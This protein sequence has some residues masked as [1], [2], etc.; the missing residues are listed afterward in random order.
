MKYDRNMGN[1]LN[2]KISEQ[3]M[4]AENAQNDLTLMI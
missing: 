2:L 4:S 1:E 3:K